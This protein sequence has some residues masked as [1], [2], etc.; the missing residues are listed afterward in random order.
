LLFVGAEHRASAAVVLLSVFFG[1]S[2]DW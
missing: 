2:L 1:C